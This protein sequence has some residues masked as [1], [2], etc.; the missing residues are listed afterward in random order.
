MVDAW[1]S[2]AKLEQ[3]EQHHEDNLEKQEDQFLGKITIEVVG[4]DASD[5]AG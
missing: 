5:H 1:A 2:M 4:D 3:T